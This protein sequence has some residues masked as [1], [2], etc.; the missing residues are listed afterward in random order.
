M[1]DRVATS[2]T[3]LRQ[4]LVHAARYYLGGRRGLSALAAAILAVGL[5]LN[6]SWLVAIGAAPL[7]LSLLPCA[8]MCA[9]GLCMS[10]MGK[11]SCSQQEPARP[12]PLNTAAEPGEASATVGELSHSCPNCGNAAEAQVPSRHRSSTTS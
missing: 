12:A 3:P 4:D 7:V 8:A 10:R 1:T 9:L 6:W 11:G 2:E 5:A